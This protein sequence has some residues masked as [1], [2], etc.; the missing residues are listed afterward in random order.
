MNMQ[1]LDM[2]GLPRLQCIEGIAGWLFVCAIRS[3]DS[4]THFSPSNIGVRTQ[5]QKLYFVQSY[6]HGYRSVRR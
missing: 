3:R 6:K 4:D 5:E 1:P 2:E